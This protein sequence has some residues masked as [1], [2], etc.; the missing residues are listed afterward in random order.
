MD[1]ERFRDLAI[2]SEMYK[3]DEKRLLEIK[4]NA[5]IKYKNQIEKIILS[6]IGLSS[7][8]FDNITE[9]LIAEYEQKWSENKL[10]QSLTKS[11]QKIHLTNAKVFISLVHEYIKIN[12]LTIDIFAGLLDW[13]MYKTL[14]DFS[15][16]SVMRPKGG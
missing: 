2:N 12:R 11:F 1:Y 9:K 8:V 16:L 6:D 13:I 4:I 10:P 7:A 15:F 5:I 14:Q 3:E